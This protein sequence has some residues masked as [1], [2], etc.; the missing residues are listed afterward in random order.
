MSTPFKMK[1]FSGFGSESP[2]TKKKRK[3]TEVHKDDEG[4]VT[5]KMTTTYRKDGTRKKS[6]T[7]WTPESKKLTKATETRSGKIKKRRTHSVI[8][9]SKYDKE[10]N[11]IWDKTTERVRKSRKKDLEG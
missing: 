10:G 2:L 1:G 4:N 7:I 6:K 11:V 9:K 3:E 5:S 8:V